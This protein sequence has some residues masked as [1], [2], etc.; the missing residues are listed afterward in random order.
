MSRSAPSPLV[1]IIVPCYIATRE[2]A[3]LLRLT[4]RATLHAVTG[5][6]AMVQA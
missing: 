3:D 6:C 2:Q 4:L 1:S 5:W